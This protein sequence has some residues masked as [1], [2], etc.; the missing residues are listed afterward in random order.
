MLEQKFFA[1]VAAATRRSI[2][3]R[4]ERAHRASTTPSSR[5]AVS[6]VTAA[7]LFAGGIALA[8]QDEAATVLANQASARGT[9][10][11]AAAPA[12]APDGEVTEVAAAATP[13][14]AAETPAA[15]E[16][17]SG[18]AYRVV[19]ADGGVF[20]HGWYGYS[21][22]AA[23]ITKSPITGVAQTADGEGYWLSSADGGVFSFGSA[24]FHGS[25]AGLSSETVVDIATTPSGHGYW[26]VS[27]TGGVF[28]F[29]DATY[30]G[31]AVE[32]KLNK[33]VTSLASTPSGKGYWLVTVDGGVL[34]FGDAEYFG[35]IADQKLN[36][37][38]MDL[39]P[40]PT[41]KGY[42][43]VSTDGGVFA[44]GDAPFLGSA[45]GQRLN[46][47]IVDMSVA[48][49]G[50]GYW[51]VAQDG[52]VFTYGNAP[53]LGSPPSLTAPVIGIVAGTGT[54]K[55]GPV[56]EVVAASVSTP[57]PAAAPAAA[58]ATA[59]AP[60]GPGRSENARGQQKKLAGAA[61]GDADYK[62]GWDISYPQCGGPYPGGEYAY[63]IIGI[64]GGR[65]FKHNRCLAD[66]W[67]WA[68]STA[69]AGVYVNVNFPR[70]N[71][72]L[73]RGA[74]SIHQ[75]N[76]NGAISCIAWNFGWNGIHDSMQYARS[77]GVDAPFVWLDVE[78]LNY[79]TPNGALNAVVLRGAI[80]AVRAHGLGVGVYS[81][82]LQYNRIM[83]GEITGVPVWSAGASSLEGAFRYCTERSFGG[84]KV[85]FVQLLP[86]QYDPNIACPGAGP[87]STY[88]K[89]P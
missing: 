59:P 61:S 48:P 51:L 78:Q 69:A 11:T 86:G 14:A 76:C 30:A 37:G 15:P 25:A 58:P 52:G 12:A 63:A 4:M 17:T 20:T 19:S 56:T 80:D 24:P 71:D 33:P 1:P 83:G 31:N 2:R 66:E 5:R 47:P 40:T 46:K 82:P 21:G 3:R 81:T 73:A 74:S 7:T 44:F 77:Q 50:D 87:L 23:G 89:L 36:A 54:Q 34:A 26:L 88:F 62:F 42:Y 39:V 75:P 79:W 6:A 18:P 60:D 72:E 64:N 32:F 68:S 35:S 16:P 28:A 43:L 49:A 29:G 27:R 13:T 10:T 55:P 38:V 67:R 9:A 85:A 65:A 45:S 41:G 22:S 84:G 57:A 8:Q 70:S 53:Y